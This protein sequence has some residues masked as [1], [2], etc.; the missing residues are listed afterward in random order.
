VNGLFRH[1]VCQPERWAGCKKWEPTWERSAWPAIIETRFDASQ[2][3]VRL[4][5]VLFPNDEN[6]AVVYELP[7]GTPAMA[8]KSNISCFLSPA[9]PAGSQRSWLVMGESGG[10]WKHLALP[11]TTVS[12]RLS[13]PTA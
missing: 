13:S 2:A 7:G 11:T 6:M 1:A 5:A 10:A 8:V 12:V 4:G 3:P 9:I